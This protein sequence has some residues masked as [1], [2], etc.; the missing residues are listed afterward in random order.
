MLV[1]EKMKKEVK[2]V[3]LLDDLLQRC[4]PKEIDSIFLLQIILK[5]ERAL[6]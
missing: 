4:E 5:E 6:L 1:R 3:H 2:S